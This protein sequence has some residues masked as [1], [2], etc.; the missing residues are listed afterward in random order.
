MPARSKV[1]GS[2]TGRTTTALALL[3]EA[4]TLKQR[5]GRA[6]ATRKLRV[7][8]ALEGAQLARARDVLR[9]HEL[10]CFWRAY[11][12]D[13]RV[14]TR[15]ERM[16]SG[17]ARRPDLIRHRQAL[18][19]SGVAGTEIRFRFFAPTARWLVERW[20]ERLRIDWPAFDTEALEPW[21]PRLVHPAEVPALDEYDMPMCEWLAWL[22]GPAE[23]DAA[24]LVRRF[25]R[26]PM[27]EGARETLYD[28]LD[29]PLILAPGP[30][31]PSR[32]HARRRGSSAHWQRR[33]LSR[34]R[35]SPAA[36]LRLRPRSVREVTPREGA[37][38]LDLARA[39]MVTRSRDLD[40]FSYGDPGDV[41]V[42]DF[43][44]GLQFACI[45]VVPQRR[46]LLEAVYGYLTLKN[47]VP[48]GYVL[49]ASLFGSAELAY[50]VFDTWRGA[51][52]GPIYARVLAM[53]RWLYGCDA[54]TIVP[55]QLGE[56]NDEALGTGAWWFYQ[57]MGFRPRA[58]GA[59]R[60]MNDEIQRMRRH[61]S[62]RS[63][64]GTLR[65]LARANLHLFLE[66]T[67]GDVLGE[68]GL[69]NVGLHVSRFVGERFGHDR[70]AARER[71]AVEAVDRLGAG[72]G[73]DW[74]RDERLAWE[75]WAPL[76]SILPVER[77]TL[78]ERHALVEV[79]RAKG[80]RRESDF[81]RRFDAHA[82]LRAAVGR[83]AAQPPSMPRRR[84]A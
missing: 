14:L 76:V 30:T 42:V 34:V 9:L 82:R 38:L 29:P 57:K 27:D 44:D 21:L 68:L 43:G 50:N 63:S 79:I 23:T 2:D 60:L 18:A 72:P 53:T 81:V 77:W 28:Q 84:P 59:L 35:P 16:L 45:G 36:V 73:S 32:T 12:D 56:G 78:A 41:R 80:G 3:T 40:A 66:R 24:F 54:F 71:C 25:H 22:K 52:A 39:A 46:L 69:A 62:H 49:T 20:P 61:P 7:L 10:L 83:L 31:T 15:V 6:V 37:R 48:I 5:F 70:E 47:G 67:R 51:E 13:R 19:D 4:E 17:F 1:Q 55:Y 26:L 74:T 75:S 65:R 64:L 11:P 33:P 8:A 58:R